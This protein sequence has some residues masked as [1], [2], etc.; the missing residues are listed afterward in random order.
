MGQEL[1]KYIDRGDRMNFFELLIEEHNNIKR[2]LKVTRKLSI[3]VMETGQVDFESFRKIID[4][5]RNYADK[6]HHSKEEEIL[7]EKMSKELGEPMASGPITAMF[8]EHDLGRLFIHNLE[9]ALDKVKNGD[10]EAK[11]DIVANAVAYTDLLKRHIEKEDHTIYRFGEN[12]LK[13]G[14]IV[15]IQKEI[16]QIEEK[17]SKQDIQTK[18]L[19]IINQLEN[20]VE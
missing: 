17:A 10:N 18:Y 15:K 13:E 12:N 6:H 3:K 5:L 16:N 11:V 19:E 9:N 8:S 20:K 1:L 2:V 7:F 14:S 4:F